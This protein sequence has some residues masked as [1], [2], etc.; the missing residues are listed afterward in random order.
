MEENKTGGNLGVTSGS[1]SGSMG[2]ATTTPNT[3]GMPE[4]SQYGDTTSDFGTTSAMET[5]GGL[6]SGIVSV[7]EKFGVNEEQLNSVRE[8]LKNV[9]ID[10]SLERAKE[11]VTESITKAREYAKRNP[12]AVAAGLA[13]LVI[14][15]GLIAAAASRRNND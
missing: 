7:L 6:S 15:A 12:A 14:G 1:M 4:S 13:V 11:Q 8:T 5:S 2:G 9:N 10:Q 3:T